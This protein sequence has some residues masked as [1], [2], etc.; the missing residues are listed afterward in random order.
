MDPAL[1]STPKDVRFVLPKV[2]LEYEQLDDLASAPTFR[3]KSWGSSGFDAPA[4]LEV[5]EA[6]RMEPEVAL[7]E[8]GR[9]AFGVGPI[10]VDFSQDHTPPELLAL[11]GVD[12]AF[13]GIYVKSLQFYYAD[14]D[15][16]LG[17]NFGIR[18]ALISFAGQVSLEARLDILGPQTTMDFEVR[19]YEGDRKVAYTRGEPVPG[20]SPRSIQ[21]GTGKLHDN[22]VVH[23]IVRGG[24]PPVTVS[25]KLDTTEIWNATDRVA[26][27]PSGTTGTKTLAVSVTDANTA[28]PQTFDESIELTILPAV[29][30]TTPAGLPADRVPAA[31]DLPTAVF[32]PASTVPAGY[33]LAHTPSASGLSETIRVLGPPGATVTIGTGPAV[34]VVDA[35]IVLDV[36]EG[37]DAAPIPIVVDWP[38]AGS[39]TFETFSLFFSRGRPD[40]EATGAL[41]TQIRDSYVADTETPN[42]ERFSTSRAPNG[43]GLVGVAALREWASN[44]VIA[45]SEIQITGAASYEIDSDGPRD[46]RL[47]QRRAEV[48]QLIVQGSGATGT[49]TTS[50]NGHDAAKSAGRTSSPLDR[51]AIIT[52]KTATATGAVTVN[53]TISRA[54]RP[55]P[56]ATPPAVP[57][58]APPPAPNKPP[59]TFRRISFRVRLERNIPVLVEVS[60]E[61]DFETEM[62]AKLRAATPASGSAPSGAT[63]TLALTPTSAATTNPNPADGIVDFTLAVTYD[64]ATHAL[65]ERL[66]LGASPDDVDGLLR[67]TNPHAGSLTAANRIRDA[68]G[69][70]L[71][72]APVINAAAAGLDPDSAGDWA[73]LSVSVAV[74]AA[75]GALGVFETQTVTL[76]GGEL[77]FRQL[78]PPAEAA[79]FTDAGVVF[80]YGVEFGI[81]IG[82]LGIATT[83]PLKV[84][85]RAVGFNLNFQG[86]V[87]YQP[88]FDT[89]QGFEIDL[90]DPGLFKL[91]APLGDI[92]KILAVR[93][94]RVNPL[95]LEADLGLKVDLG[96]VTVDRFRVKWP[97]DPLGVP[98][99][100]PTG[101]KI[102]IPGAIAGSG[103]VNIIEPPSGPASSDQISSS[104]FEGM[105][106]ASIVPIKLRIA[107]SLGVQHVKDPAN[108]R[109]AVAIFAGLIVDF[110]A[111]LPILQSGIGLYGLAGLF[112]MH[113]KRL[114][115]PPVPGD[116]VSPALHWLVKAGGEPAKLASGSP[117]VP[118][119][120][121][122]LDRWSFGVGARLGT[123][124]GGFLANLRG[125]LVV[126]LPGPRILIFV[127]V[128]V[129]AKLEGLKPATNLT[130][131]ILGVV[132]LDFNLWTFTVG[133]L[134]DLEVKDIVRIQIPVELFFGLKAPWPWHLNIGTFESKATAT[135]LNLVKAYG[136]F[137]ISGEAITGW[138]GYGTV[139]TLSPI[140]VATGI[141][142]SITL[143]DED[144]G[145]YLRASAKA[146]LGV[147]IFPKK[148]YMVGRVSLEGELR[149]FIVSIEASG[150]LDVEA[151]DPTY[152]DGEICGKVDFFF[153]SVSGCVGLTIGS[154]VRQL[155]TPDLLDSVFLQSHAPVLTAGQADRAID[156]S[157]GDAFRVPTPGGA[158]P[159]ATADPATDPV[160]TVPIDSVPVLQLRASPL[161]S[162]TT[163]FTKPLVASPRQTPGGWT[164]VG[165]GRQVKYVLKEI[166]LDPPL[167][168]TTAGLPPA[169]WRTETNPQQV[170]AAKTNIDLALMSRVPTHGERALERSSELTESVTVRWDGACDPVAP[171]VCV[172]WTFCGEPIGPSGEGWQLEGV[173]QP[174]PPGTTRTTPPPT[175][176]Y[177]EEPSPATVDVLAGRL[178][179][180]AGV[181]T[182]QPAKVIGPGT[183]RPGDPNGGR[184]GEG[185]GNPGNPGVDLV[186][187]PY[188]RIAEGDS[189]N[190]RRDAGMALD[191]RDFS[192]NRLARSRIVPWGGQRGL[193]VGF[194][195]VVSL[196]AGSRV[197][198]LTLVHLSEPARV[199]A[200]NADGTSSAAAMSV[201][202]AVPETLRLL[203][204]RIVRLVID[205]PKDET[206]LLSLCAEA[207]PADRTPPD[208]REPLPT[209]DLR[210]ARLAHQAGETLHR[211]D[212]RAFEAVDRGLVEERRV[213]TL[214]ALDRPP[215]VGGLPT[216]PPFGRALPGLRPAMAP[217]AGVDTGGLDR[218]C[219]RALQ[220]PASIRR[221]PVRGFKPSPEGAKYLKKLKPASWI[222][223]HTGPANLVRL[224]L[225]VAAP[226]PGPSGVVLR[227][228]DASG[229]V[230]REDV[231][232]TLGPA[233]VTGVTTGLPAE[234]LDAPWRAQVLP[235]ATFL[236]D[237]EFSALE[238]WLVSLK[239]EAKT[240]RIQVAV[241]LPGR[242]VSVPEVL[243][244][245]V[246]VCPTA[247]DERVANDEAVRDGQIETLTGYLDG[248]TP[249]PLLAK[250]TTYRLRVR[251]DAVSKAADGSEST[252][253]RT[254]EFGFRTD[255]AEP[256]RL[257]PWVLGT[258]PNDLEQFAFWRD[259]LKI[260]FNDLAILQLFGTYG[261]QLRILLRAA[262]G[263]PIADQEVTALAPVDA[264][265]WSPYRDV[266][267][268]LIGLGLLPCVGSTTFP[269]HGSWTSAVELR[270][271]MAYTLDV[272][273]DPPNAAPAADKPILP[274]FRR[275]FTTGRF[276]DLGALV[277]D[278]T[279]RRI[280]H[281][282]LT[283][284]LAGLPTG[285]VA[286][287]TDQSIQAAL[288]AAGE[289]ALPA[290]EENG[291]LVYWAKRS[292]ATTFSP[293]AIL[294]DAAEPL[295]R[296][297]QEPKLEV[298][299]GQSDPAYQRIVPGEAPSLELIE[300]GTSGIERFVHSPSGTRTLAIV[301]NSF[302][303]G[304][305]ASIRLAVR[306]PASTLY[307]LSASVVTL[308][309]IAFGRVAPWE[310][311]G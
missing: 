69:A 121:M 250:D 222:T 76:Y 310:E 243:V 12:E 132:D 123:M 156:A 279:G 128:E 185:A 108:N 80:D 103:F 289:Q 245:V 100:L 71:V 276:A 49:V 246:E 162:A 129:V 220:L 13:E 125:M 101:A 42:D 248:D 211:R 65:T 151:P 190:P 168:T 205:A 157:L 226:A 46:V 66:A 204:T 64:T 256:R 112:A 217:A 278:L 257:D 94:A 227:Q 295:W 201:P 25:V 14:S 144:I 45:G 107:A 68:F 173:P 141:A 269:H 272:V 67:M 164:D 251:Y 301:K 298:V 171:A 24:A 304:G 165:G 36:P 1:P 214:P 79:T 293:H 170:S 41:Y 84:R 109:E 229:G 47:S 9:I 43:D 130:V 184:P 166:V 161:V 149:I 169:T 116:A 83:R 158:I 182:P 303:P 73:V 300:Q 93:I 138:P 104:G 37:T 252:E 307:G 87:T 189:P 233:P 89:S 290:P 146:D 200:Y 191:I 143:G 8:S 35:R 113:Y 10:V 7:H 153:F 299:P 305:N 218:D 198:E 174:D 207:Q 148:M 240:D 127:K 56:S 57:A 54:A 30:A 96:V 145:L 225:A 294:V 160:P 155:P 241:T 180:P 172:L 126:E 75:I 254:Q 134:V 22:A 291:V 194:R 264:D 255:A 142:A 40:P 175:G 70:M 133:V 137:Q 280:R 88:I 236:A 77:R 117:P 253:D 259:P 234:W 267:E 296:T 131:G 86:G 111:P 193:D 29:A 139:R 38:A 177:V 163:T 34:V 51:V 309:E 106:D 91:P 249:V 283:S 124:E 114:E 18:D 26:H 21:G 285:S 208:R 230:V 275:S 44:R 192:G 238:R 228:L 262:D 102:D 268:A 183:G 6:V 232:A 152:L 277:D 28:S 271:L 4:D 292:G 235:V 159:A 181:G 202:Q 92:L 2:V 223:L 197:V 167:P 281:R 33:G 178:A 115:D 15:K 95:T 60:G 206:L 216:A 231:L 16:S 72:L 265:F 196:P 221:G 286:I 53:A 61:L 136:Y 97:L 50:A 288:V 237:A 110:P 188:G 119:W 3:V 81:Q 274:L 17:F 58:P 247:E 195:T 210:R 209:A 187:V 266:L 311:D 261:K 32:S 62:E 239:P 282:F 270:P 147:S 85:Y 284:Q 55:A 306:R 140:A 224:V 242:T 20:G 105:L 90:S 219:F 260:V 308:S 302:T 82:Q 244:G 120:G 59:S 98:S 78:I 39:D 74:P 179:G 99:I 176:L 122:E 23:V 135:V 19:L 31:G 186:C 11:F 5:G 27:I 154:N 287:A 263:V 212:L 48:A 199:T 215:A 63:G 52:G 273:V 213:R 118:V 258:T 203:G 150:H 297:R